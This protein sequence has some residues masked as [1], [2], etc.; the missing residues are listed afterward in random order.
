MKA[1]VWW[2]IYVRASSVDELKV[3]YIPPI[4]A[5][6]E[7]FSFDWQILRESSDVGLFR[8]INYQNL[9]SSDSVGIIVPV[10]R[11][12]YRLASTWSISGLDDLDGRELR[13]VLGGWSSKEPSAT[14]GLFS[15]MFEIEPGEI[16]GMNDQGGWDIIGEPGTVLISPEM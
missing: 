3:K 9:E 12:A 13:H 1:Y 14:G 6:L 8:I 16:A 10:L 4:D 7:Q 15:M 2:S 11:R 5:A